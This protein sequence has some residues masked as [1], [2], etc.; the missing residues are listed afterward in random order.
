[1]KRL[2][3]TTVLL[4]IA[5]SCRK[6]P[7]PTRSELEKLTGTPVETI[8]I[9][10]KY[11]L[12]S[13]PSLEE[14]T[15]FETAQKTHLAVLTPG[16]KG[17]TLLRHHA[18]SSVLAE[19][20]IFFIATGN[21]KSHILLTYGTGKKSL[22]LFDAAD[23]MQVFEGDSFDTMSVKMTKIEEKPNDEILNLGQV[24]YRFNGMQWLPWQADEIWPFLEQFEVAGDQSVI[25]ISNRGQFGTRALVTLAFPE[26]KAADLATRLKLTK[27]ISTVN[28]YRPGASVHK[29][30]GGNIALPHP[31]IEIR[32]DSWSKN[33]RI[34]LPLFMANVRELTLR[35]VYSQRGQNLNWPSAA[36]PG[37][38]KDGQGYFAAYRK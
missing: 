17:Y 23:F 19:P 24:A 33:A 4:L 10:K 2:M 26:I 12:D 3:A 8:L 31:L 38:V 18:F 21:K 37:I 15:L 32:K 7:H 28:L 35:A 36:G 34:R 6:S 1:M 25:E 22:A 30:G 14:I 29:N 11:Q 27:E 9:Q 5:A 13:S 16:D 20:K